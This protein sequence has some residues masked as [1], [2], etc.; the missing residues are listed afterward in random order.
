MNFELGNAHI[1]N[2]SRQQLA[3]S[4]TLY[5]KNFPKTHR[6]TISSPGESPYKDSIP[7]EIKANSPINYPLKFNSLHQKYQETSIDSVSLEKDQPDNMPMG[8]KYLNNINR[9]NQEIQIMS[10]QLKLSNETIAILTSR[11]C[12]TNHKHAIQI[13]ELHQRHEQKI[14]KMK[15]DIEKLFA[16][17]S[18]KPSSS[19]LQ[20]IIMEKNFELEE[21]QKRFSEKLQIITE[22]HE[23]QLKYRDIEHSS[24]MRTLKKQFLEV[25]QELQEKFFTEIENLQKNHRMDVE[26]VKEAL[27]AIN[28][29]E[30]PSESEISTAIEI[31]H[32]KN[33][34]HDSLSDLQIIEELSFQQNMVI[35]PLEESLGSNSEFDA[36]LRQ[37]INQIGF[38]NEV[39]LT[40]M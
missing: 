31:D 38:E 33:K 5:P 15:S 34:H 27:K 30:N 22:M 20:K 37:L 3:R 17:Q 21:Q 36:S 10:N 18:S 32:E 40:D 26:Q 24:K 6:K 11:L 28:N 1:D 23:K 8:K 4:N 2:L 14:T 13:Q 12:E 25:V 35:R 16:Q 39:S 29:K 19:S 7:T 9:L